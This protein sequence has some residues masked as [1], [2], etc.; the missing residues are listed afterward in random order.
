MSGNEA[1]QP[2]NEESVR[3]MATEMAGRTSCEVLERQAV[4]L[5]AT[6]ERLKA[7]ALETGST[8]GAT[9]AAGYASAGRDVA[10]VAAG[11]RASLG[12]PPLEG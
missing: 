8:H 3:R 4:V 9:Y 6:A 12:I 7:I 1:G 2:M 10:A 11:M 5:R